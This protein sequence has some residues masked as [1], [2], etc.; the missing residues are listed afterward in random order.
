MR[1]ALLAAGTRKKIPADSRIFFLNLLPSSIKCWR[2]K[3][4]NS[5]SNF[6]L[7]KVQQPADWRCHVVSSDE[8]RCCLATPQEEFPCPF[9]SFY[10][11]PKCT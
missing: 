2:E 7:A 5:S 11:N 4:R 1:L 9:F 6:F 3:E 8:R 10:E